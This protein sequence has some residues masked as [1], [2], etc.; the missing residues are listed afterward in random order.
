MLKQTEGG[1]TISEQSHRRETDTANA[2]HNLGNVMAH[3]I[4]KSVRHDS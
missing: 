2:K 3:D 1:K 4:N